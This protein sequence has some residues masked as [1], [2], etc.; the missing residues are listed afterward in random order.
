MAHFLRELQQGKLEVVDANYLSELEDKVKSLQEDND[1]M[2]MTF[3]S[4][5]AARVIMDEMR[6]ILDCSIGYDIMDAIKK[7]KEND[8]E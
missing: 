3:H 8:N 6:E 7:L 5:N 4:A 1:K 2:M